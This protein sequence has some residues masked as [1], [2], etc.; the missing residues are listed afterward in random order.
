MGKLPLLSEYSRLPEGISCEA[1]RPYIHDFLDAHEYDLNFL[2]EAH[3]L[4]ELALRQWHTYEKADET[5]LHRIAAYLSRRMDLE[6][7]ERAQEYLGVALNFGL[8]DLVRKWEKQLPDIKNESSRKALAE[9]LKLDGLHPD[10]PYFSLTIRQGDGTK[11]E[12]GDDTPANDEIG[13]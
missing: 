12:K 6:D 2:D 7:T 13:K 4:Q 3:D 8:G 9:A 10:D 1:L 5:T 11:P